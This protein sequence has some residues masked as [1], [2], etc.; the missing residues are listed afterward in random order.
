MLEKI[1]KLKENGTKV[2]TEL[3]AGVTTFMAIS[4]IIF[5][6]PTILSQTGMDYNAVYMATILA[7]IFGTLFVGLF[8]NVPYV[9]SAG[10]GIN[11]LFTYT[12]CMSMGFT[13][14]QGLAMVFICGVISGIITLTSLRKKLI[15][16]IPPFFQDAITVGIGLFIAYTGFRNTGL[17]QFTVNGVTDGIASGSSTIPS[18]VTFN[19]PAVILSIIGLIITS[20]LLLRKVKGAYLIGILLTTL[21]GI[22]LG[23][24]SLPDFSNYTILPSLEPTFLKLDFAGLFTAEAGIVVVIM[25][26]FTLCISDLFDSVGTFIGTGKKS[27]IFSIDENGKM[28]PKLERALFADSISTS[29]GALLGTSNVTSYVESSAGIQAGGRTGLTSVF[30]ALCFAVSLLVYPLVACVPMAAIAPILILIGVSMIEAV[31]NIDWKDLA[32]ALPAFF[33]IVLMPFSY[34]ITTG[35]QIGFL[36]YII[37]NVALGKAKN[38]SPIIYLFSILFIIDFV[39]KAIG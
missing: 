14:Q 29:V 25:T 7:S 9:L 37:S 6:N 34:S 2:S 8:A 18:L 31:G 5:I 1:F 23:V 36:F 16:A 21:I 30:A 26:I 27:G 3:I 15:A 12:I 17:I 10:L 32:I 4:Y 11:S 24:T 19:T 13:W 38:V 22:P 35:I 33:T 20:I 28:S 39:Y